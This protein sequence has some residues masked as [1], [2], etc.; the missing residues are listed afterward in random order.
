MRKLLLS[1]FLLFI[2]TGQS[3]AVVSST[4]NQNEYACNSSNTLWN[5]TFPI[6]LP[7][8]I[9]VYTID[10]MGNATQQT[11]NFSVN[12]NTLTVT[13]PVTGTPC[14][15][16]YSLL[17]E[18]IEPFT[19][20]VAASNQGP[21]PSPVVM[22]MSDKLT[23]LAQQLSNNSVQSS[24]G[25]AGNVVL[26]AYSA[27]SLLA[28]SSTLNQL[29]NVS[30]PSAVAQWTLS[31]AN[32]SYNTGNVSTTNTMT[33]NLFNGNI[34]WS[35]LPSVIPSGSVNWNDIGGHATL[36][37]GGINWNDTN[38]RGV[39]NSGGVNWNDINK[40]SKMN[41]GGINWT[42][43]NIFPTSATGNVGIGSSNPGQVLDVVGTVRAT[44]FTGQSGTGIAKT[45]TSISV[46]NIY[47]PATSDGFVR[48]IKVTNGAS[49]ITINGFANTS[50]TPS[51]GTDLCAQQITGAT[52]ESL[53]CSFYVL[54]GWYYE[55]TNGD[56]GTF[57]P[58]GS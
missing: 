57:T 56:A 31:G 3:H 27:G 51:G 26:P 17:L 30:N 22:T 8:D 55:Y 19:Q 40:F 43:T 44:N 33:A 50:A 25:T 15:T 1:I 5:Y 32:I 48:I 21:A 13:Y 52:V 45:P 4:I 11:S 34:N 54:K 2:L 6:I 10:S 37:S 53:A 7:T 16:G 42:S 29:A 46:N 20:L 41:Y 18:R 24:P 39:L 14:A 38:I 12:T 58:I 9:Q 47:G 28:W 49:A 36:N 23:M 35:D